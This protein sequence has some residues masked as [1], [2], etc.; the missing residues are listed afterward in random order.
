MLTQASATVSPFESI[1][2]HLL[3]DNLEVFPNHYQNDDSF[4]TFDIN[5]W[6]FLQDS[7]ESSQNIE[8]VSNFCI[9]FSSSK[10]TDFFSSCSSLIPPNTVDDPPEHLPN[11]YDFDAYDCLVDMSNGNHEGANSSHTQ[12][13]TQQIFQNINLDGFTDIPIVCT[14]PQPPLSPATFSNL[15]AIDKKMEKAPNKPLK[16]DFTSGQVIPIN[17]EAP[18]SVNYILPTTRHGIQ[19]KKVPLLPNRSYRGVRQRRWGKFTAEMRNPEKNGKRLWLGTYDTPEEAAMAYDRAAF[20]HRGS[21]ALLNF[22]QMI[23]LHQEK[24]KSPTRKKRR[25]GKS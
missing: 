17:A 24:S 25:I 1:R 21:H 13:N 3:D 15:I 10:S 7:N 12:N 8:N 19:A 14:E 4:S 22:P 23:G 16:L 18:L 9:E 6:S 5:D 11:L 2:N 20:K